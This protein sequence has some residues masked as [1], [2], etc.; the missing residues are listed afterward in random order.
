MQW[1]NK[2]RK[3]VEDAVSKNTGSVAHILYPEK[4]EYWIQ[5]LNVMAAWLSTY[6]KKQVPI[7]IIGDYDC[8]GVCA[9][10]E[11]FLAL[12]TLGATKIRTRLPKR[13]SEGYGLSEKIVD[14]IHEGII[15]T[16][17][18]GIAAIDSIKKAK[19]KGLIVLVIDHHQPKKEKGEIILPPADL[20]VD[21]AVP[22]EAIKKG[23]DVPTTFREYCGAGLVY[24]VA[25][26]LNLD[27]ITLAKISA[28]A[29]VATVADMV[30]LLDD[31]RI[32][33]K[34]GV[35]NIQKGNVTR[36]LYAIVNQ[37]QSGGIVSESDIGFRIGPMLNAPGRIYD[38]GASISLEAV[39]SETDSHAQYCAEN[40]RQINEK[41]KELKAAGVN[42]AIQQIQDECLFM[43][44]PI[45]IFDKEIPE[46]IV[47]LV[48]GE[49]QE[50]FHVTAIVLTEKDGYWKGSARSGP[51]D[52]IKASLDKLNDL[53]S[54]IFVGY[55]GHP[56]AAGLSVHA[57]KLDEFVEGM[58]KVMQDPV[59]IP[60][61]LEYDLE[62]KAD[63][64]P[65]F[66]EMVRQFAPFGQGNPS[67]VFKV[68]G[69]K[70]VP[71]RN[72]HYTE[73]KNGSVKFLGTGCEAI[74]FSMMEKYRDENYPMN[75]DFIG[76][77]S[78]HCF[79]GRPVPQIEVLDLKA[80][81]EK[82]PKTELFDT[83]TDT[84]RIQGLHL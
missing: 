23:P 15:V 71:Y 27:A 60:D 46:G 24:K 59:Q 70:P 50:T 65:A 20:I 35:S 77:L 74:A 45:C 25:Q 81:E 12:R 69:F 84:L 68:N 18:N 51:G 56:G 6:A 55:G 13:M 11:L 21:P 53:D 64:V 57:D 17:D 14:E 33:F 37:L 10:A 29:A 5:N 8:D 78:Y 32:I 26:L 19:E 54:S 82:K 28:L 43:K 61:E 66:T 49:I 38:D 52:D 67:I 3:S 7:T 36:G 79:M 30:P 58:D 41:R 83:I 22:D 16:V 39:L 4:K 34:T 73:I 76:T 72:S 62:I 1:K 80:S 40:L 63:Q 31:N 75:M 42:R 44:N 9:T 2:Q 48:A 47:G